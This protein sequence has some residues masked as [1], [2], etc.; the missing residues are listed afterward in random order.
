MA[1]I[2]DQ[3]VERRGSDG[4]KWIQYGDDVLPLWVADMDFVSPQAI[5]DA[6]HSRVDEGVFGYVSDIPG[7]RQAICDR[8]LAH[9][10]WAVDPDMVVYLPGVVSAIN[11]VCQAIGEPGD[12]VLINTPVYPPFLSAPGNQDRELHYGDQAVHVQDHTLRYEIDFDALEAA[13]RPNTRVFILCNPHNPTGRVFTEDE[14]TRLADMCERHDL[15]IC[16]DEIHCELLLDGSRHIPTATLSPQISDRTI[17]LLAPSKTFNIPSLH[18]SLV[19]IPNPKLRQQIKDS[20]AGLI[21]SPNVLSM[22]AARSAYTECD[23]WLADLLEYLT[24]NRD[25]LVDYVKTHLPGLR[26]T[27]PEGTY[28]AWIDCRELPIEGSPFDFFLNEAKV[29]FNN[30]PTFGQA[31]EGF[32]RL[33][34][35]CPRAT[36]QEA[37]ERMRTAMEGLWASERTVG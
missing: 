35:G 8:L 27:V 6:V 25:F 7:L 34:F 11:V 4:Y 37:L 12:G 30:G 20:M 10:D 13:I 29:A 26:V 16:S 14:L 31:G 23:D 24:A 36:L 32:V 22:Y 5:L 9:Y 15:V 3:I 17:T 19:V 18:F 1:S 33:N 21:S 2:F 28:L